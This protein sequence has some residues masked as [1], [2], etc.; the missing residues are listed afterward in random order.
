LVSLCQKDCQGDI[1]LKNMHYADDVA[2][3]SDT[4]ANASS[5]LNYLENA[6]KD[7][8]LLSIYKFQLT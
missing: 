2:L 4:V 6:A 7:V 1:L 3:T 8:G 5:L